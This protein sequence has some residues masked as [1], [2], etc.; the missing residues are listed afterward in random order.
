MIR[1]LA[2]S[3][4]LLILDNSD[5]YADVVKTLTVDQDIVD[6]LNPEKL[7]DKFSKIGLEF[8]YVSYLSIRRFIDRL[9]PAIYHKGNFVLAIDEAHTFI[10]STGFS[11]EM[12]K[13]ARSARKRAIDLVII[14]QQFVDVAKTV[15]KQAHIMVIF[16]MT[17]PAELEYL[18]SFGID[19]DRVRQ[20]PPYHAFVIDFQTGKEEIIKN[21]QI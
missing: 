8:S 5:E 4:S 9:C 20:L 13:L 11:I 10:P 6:K 16:Q 17:H 19:A 14:T 7:I 12:E 2:D 3:R 15:L 18:R 1:R 21:D